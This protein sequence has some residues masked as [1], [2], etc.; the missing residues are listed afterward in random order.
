VLFAAF[1]LISS[2]SPQIHQPT[3]TI[4]AVYGP[5]LDRAWSTKGEPLARPNPHF[6]PLLRVV[7]ATFGSASSGGRLFIEVQQYLAGSANPTFMAQFGGGM[8]YSPCSV[9][10][11]GSGEGRH[12]W[13]ALFEIAS[14]EYR[15]SNALDVR[16]G[17]A[18]GTWNTV[19][20]A[21]VRPNALPLRTG[22]GFMR[23][24]RPW[25][26]PGAGKTT[27]ARVIVDA[28]TP[29]EGSA[30]QYRVVLFDQKGNAMPFLEK[31]AGMANMTQWWFAG[32]YESVRRVDLQ[33]RPVTWRDYPKVF[34]RPNTR[35]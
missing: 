23:G 30:Q 6:D 29:A 26:V 34:S 1:Y 32:E 20:S 18:S 27:Q 3:P 13:R 25:E 35:R 17:A 31:K 5:W 19:G 4:V 11:V 8:V 16:V 15:S 24:I 7:S 22:I 10:R 9:R 12:Y 21:T 28:T 14:R 33:A 2:A